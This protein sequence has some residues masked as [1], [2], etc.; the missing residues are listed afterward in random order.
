MY[1]AFYTQLSEPIHGT[2]IFEGRLIK[3]GEGH[4]RVVQ[5]RSPKDAQEITDMA[6]VLS[7]SVF[8]LFTEHIMPHRREEFRGL[9]SQVYPFGVRINGPPMIEITYRG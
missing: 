1:E 4:G 7:T 8:F 2:D 6:Y 5:L 3:D 9:F